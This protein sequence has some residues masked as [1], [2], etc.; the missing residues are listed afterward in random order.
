MSLQGNL[1]GV[2]GGVGSGKSS[3]LSANLGKM[4]KE[5]GQVTIDGSLAY[6]SQQPWIMNSTL[7]DNILFGEPLNVEKSALILLK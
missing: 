5:S 1:I 6:V 4:M 7:K 2:C 3:L